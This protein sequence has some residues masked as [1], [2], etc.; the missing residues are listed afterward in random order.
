MRPRINNGSG[1]AI[2]AASG[3]AL[4]GWPGALLGA[5]LGAAVT[6]QPLPL[7]AALRQACT[8]YGLT[9]AFWRRKTKAD[10]VVVVRDS[11]DHYW[12]LCARAEPTPTTT[13]DELDD[14]LYDGFVQECR[15]WQAQHGTS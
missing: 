3:A 8:A 9:L 6:Q 15:Q 14:A 5:F 12:T 10:I 13:P 7:E 11:S 1:L 4:G 2:G